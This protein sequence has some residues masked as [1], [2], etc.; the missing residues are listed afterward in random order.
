M[1][2]HHSSAN[3]TGPTHHS[4]HL[5][6]LWAQLRRLQR[7]QVVEL[8]LVVHGAHQGKAVAVREQCLDAGADLWHR[9]SG[10]ASAQ[11][12]HTATA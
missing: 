10:S 7:I 5:L 8:A 12:E 3:L 6:E 9:V 1:Q 2:A 11:Q 4:T